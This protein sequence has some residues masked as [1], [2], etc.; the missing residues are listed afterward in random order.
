MPEPQMYPVDSSNIEAVGYDPEEREIY[1]RFLDG[2]T[3][4]YGNADESTFVD[5]RSADSVGSYFNRVIK[6]DFP[7]RQ[8]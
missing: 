5:L 2:R 4:A 8:L 7:C 6:P 1:I 3:Y